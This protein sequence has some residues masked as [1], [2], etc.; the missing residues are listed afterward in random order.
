MDVL[1]R[2]A[3]RDEAERKSEGRCTVVRDDRGSPQWMA[4]VPKFRLEDIDPALG[5]GVHPAFIVDG[6]ERDELLIGRYIG[7]RGSDGHCHVRPDALPWTR[8]PLEEAYAECRRMGRNFVL[9]SNALYAARILWLWKTCPGRHFAGNTGYGRDARCYW[10]LGRLNTRVRSAGD[11]D[12]NFPVVS[13]DGALTYTGSGGSD[14]NDD[15]TEWGLADLVGNVW[16]WCSG[17]R[18]MDGEI[19]IIPDN[20]AMGRNADLSRESPQWK[21]VLQDGGLVHLGTEGTL[22][23]DAPCSGTGR[24]ENLG[25]AVLDTEIRNTV[26]PKAFLSDRFSSLSSAKGVKVPALLK[27]LCIHPVADD[28]QGFYWIRNGGERMPVRGGGDWSDG[29]HAGPAAL[30]VFHQRYKHDWKFSFRPAYVP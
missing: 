10:M 17:F 7:S 4:V 11:H 1:V 2:D 26:I 12:L 23:W 5:S 13:P 6:R 29:I 27:A 19:Q 20:D 9:P 3:L 30:F 15:G 21:S 18:L 22:K 25:Q 24:K 28:M 14:W 8:L 16:E